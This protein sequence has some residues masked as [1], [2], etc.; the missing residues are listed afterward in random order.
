MLLLELVTIGA[1]NVMIGAC[2]TYAPINWSLLLLEHFPIV[3]I[4]NSNRRMLVLEHSFN[5]AFFY[6][7]RAQ[8]NIMKE[9]LLEQCSSHNI[10]KCYYWR[11]API[12][13]Y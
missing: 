12:I 1:P 6:K 13:T 5:L 11:N 9:I 4:S 7:K 8:K 2:E 3:T 10:M